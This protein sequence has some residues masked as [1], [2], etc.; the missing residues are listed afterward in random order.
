MVVADPLLTADQ[1]PELA[2]FLATRLD[3]DY[4]DDPRRGCARRA[5]G[6][7]T[8][9]AGCRRRSPPRC[10]TRPTS[11]GLRGPRHPSRPGARLPGRGR[12]RQPGRLRGHRRGR[13]RGFERTFDAMLAGTDGPRA[14]PSAAATGSRS[15]RTP[16]SRP[17]TAR[18]CST[19][20]DLTCSGT[21][22]ACCARPS[23]T[24]RAESGF[25]VVMDTA[26]G[27]LLALADHPTFDASDPLQSPAR[28]LGSRAM[29]DVYE[30]GSVEKVLTIGR[31]HRR[32]QGQPRAPGCT[33]RGSSTA[34]TARSTTG[35]RTAGSS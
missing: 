6:S 20:I 26:T 28:D 8:S 24:P 11:R 32:R 22:S 27:E 7:S 10:S 9:P 33:C 18:T 1:A 14:T 34:T 12:G 17:S 16:S 3:V 5:A 15:A 31:S 2:K 13:W 4:F 35:S 30:P 23:R 25:A 19:T 21:P 29:S